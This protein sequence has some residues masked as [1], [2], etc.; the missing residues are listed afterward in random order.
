[1]K[2]VIGID[3]GGSKTHMKISTLDYKVLLEVFKGPSNINSSTKEEVKR[4]LQE[5]IME[6]LGKLGQSLEECSAICIG[7][8]GAD[9]TEDKSIIEDMIRSLGYMG[10]IIVVNDAE[11]ALAGGIEKR[12]GIIVISG[13]G[14]I[15]YGR[16]KEGRSARSGGWGHIIGDEG[17]GYD[18]GIKAIKAALKS[19]DKRGEKT[20]L[21]GDIL[22]FLKLKSHEDLINYIYRSGVT[23][24]EIAS[25]TRVVNSAYIKGDLVSKRILK[26]AARELFLSVKAVVEVLSMQ[27]KK[28]VLTTAGGVINNINYL[29]DEFRKFLNLNYPKVKIISMKNDSAFG[30][31]IIARSECD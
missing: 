10:K 16:N 29:Y 13:T 28:V 19:F 22:D 27:N 31:V 14:S 6:G 12:E 5:L 26:E 8:A 11:I 7:T 30:A 2:Y 4:V 17:S 1:M 24:K 3:G 21:E 20:I 9:R 15:C 25:L 23:K 18:I